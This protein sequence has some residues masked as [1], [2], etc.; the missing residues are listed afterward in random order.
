MLINL[1]KVKTAHRKYTF[2][3]KH[4]MRSRTKKD[5]VGTFADIGNDLNNEITNLCEFVAYKIEKQKLIQENTPQSIAGGIIYFVS[6]TCN[7][8]ISKKEINTISKIS[9]VTINK[10]F[11][12]LESLQSELIPKIILDKY[13]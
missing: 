8:N 5:G 13:C 10:C 9:E 2:T 12:K 11:K 3:I 6:F 7:L 4:N 1:L